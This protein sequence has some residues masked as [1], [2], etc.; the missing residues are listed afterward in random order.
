MKKL[1]EKSQG[2][3]WRPKQDLIIKLPNH[4][5]AKLSTADSC[6]A[7]QCAHLERGAFVDRGAFPL[8]AFSHT[9]SAR[10]ETTSFARSVDKPWD[11]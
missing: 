2:V 9:V 6:G 1:L 11:F 10:A 4:M 7:R 5:F 3:F 8:L